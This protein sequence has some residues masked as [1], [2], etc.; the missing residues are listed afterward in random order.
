MCFV[1]F[2]MFVGDFRG[3]AGRSLALFFFQF[4]FRCRVLVYVD[5]IDSLS[6]LHV[7]S[8]ME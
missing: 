8:D 1:G 3:L 7:S 6:T 4:F 5:G 2:G